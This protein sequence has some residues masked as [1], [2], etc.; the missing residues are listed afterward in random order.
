MGTPLT[1]ASPSY[2]AGHDQVG[3]NE[4][5]DGALGGIWPR[6]ALKGVSNDLRREVPSPPNADGLSVAVSS[7]HATYGDRPYLSSF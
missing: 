3:R 5:R 7:E 6:I 1:A 2:S 4:R